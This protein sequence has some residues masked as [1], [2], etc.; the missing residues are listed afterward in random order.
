MKYVNLLYHAGFANEDRGWDGRP[1]WEQ[2]D[3]FE[4]LVKLVVQDCAK[5]ALEQSQQYQLNDDTFAAQALEN[6]RN[7]ILKRYA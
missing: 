4:R 7:L 3:N 1:L 2:E 6:Y 5:V